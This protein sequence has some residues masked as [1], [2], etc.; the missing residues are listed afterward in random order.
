MILAPMPGFKA[1]HHNRKVVGGIDTMVGDSTPN[2]AVI[3][4]EVWNAILV[5]P[6][7][8]EVAR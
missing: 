6:I 1:H 3:V 8:E 4:I 2:L 7:C 5:T